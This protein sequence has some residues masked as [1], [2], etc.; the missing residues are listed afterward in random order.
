[1]LMLAPTKIHIPRDKYRIIEKQHNSVVGH[2]G[3]IPTM[4]TLRNGKYQW[5]GKGDH[6][7]TFLKTCAICQKMSQVKPIIYATPFT[8]ASYR[9]MDTLNIDS[10]GPV[11]TDRFGSCHIIVKICCFTRFIELYAAADTSAMSAA[12]ALLNHHGRYGVPNK[13]RS[14]KGSQFVNELI[15]NFYTLVGTEADLTTAY[16]KEENGIVERANKKVMRHLRVIILDRR[17]V[18]HW[19]SD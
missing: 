17:I 12:R 13:V 14:D 6:V 10:I 1:M 3:Y 16:S 8:A 11:S 15:K 2:F 7:Q 9:P 4:R 5:R 18:N 19:S